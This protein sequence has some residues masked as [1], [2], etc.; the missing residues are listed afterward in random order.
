M[1]TQRGGIA[2]D[3]WTRFIFKT[4]ALELWTRYWSRYLWQAYQV[5]PAARPGINPRR[6]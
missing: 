4:L 5:L 1:D 3:R 2:R 6:M